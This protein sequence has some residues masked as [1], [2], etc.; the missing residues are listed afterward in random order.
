MFSKRMS[1][2]LD[3]V[4]LK[5]APFQARGVYKRKTSKKFRGA[6]VK[7]RGFPDGSEVKNL[8]ERQV[9]SLGWQD[10][11]EKGMT[12]PSSIVGWN[13][14]WSEEPSGLQYKRLQRDMTK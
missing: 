6:S 3:I 12:T 5:C 8:Q 2:N 9:Q 7:E 4:P 10:R 1:Q 11:L 14:L 13:I